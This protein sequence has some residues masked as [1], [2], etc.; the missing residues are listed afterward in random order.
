MA[1]EL[2]RRGVLKGG[3]IAS[4]VVVGGIALSACSAAEEV[5]S[6][7]ASEGSTNSIPI[8]DIPV[9]GGVIPADS[10][11]VITQPAD[12]EFHAFTAV[13]PHGGCLVN[14]VANNEIICPCHG[15]RF[16]A[17]DGSVLAG[18]AVEGLAEASF[19][20]TGSDV[21]FG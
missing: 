4:G 7:V 9:G 21:S 13:C 11:V 1:H 14:E 19:E 17:T 8:A 10:S 5:G 12:G 18:P 15:S 3:A 2:D 6:A 20:V 16:S